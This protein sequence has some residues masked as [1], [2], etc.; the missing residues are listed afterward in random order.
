MQG[1]RAFISIIILYVVLKLVS[2]FLIYLSFC[3]CSFLNWINIPL[4]GGYIQFHKLK[5]RIYMAPLVWAQNSSTIQRIVILQKKAARIINFQP[6]NF[7]NSPLFK[8]SS[9]LKFQDKFC[10]ESILLASANL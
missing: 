4:S 5:L 8:Q 1:E 9:I 10:L 3:V 7:H 6:R 2:V